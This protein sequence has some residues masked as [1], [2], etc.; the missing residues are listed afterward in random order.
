[1]R[2]HYLTFRPPS[3]AIV[4]EARA[5]WTLRHGSELFGKSN[6]TLTAGHFPRTRQ[7]RAASHAGPSRPQFLSAKP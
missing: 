4:A 1:M 7:T 5:N 2:A 3:S 6:S